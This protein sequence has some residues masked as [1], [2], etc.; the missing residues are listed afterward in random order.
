M[1]KKLNN[2][3]LIGPMGAGKTTIGK[4]LAQLTNNLFYD[5]DDEIEKQKEKDAKKEAEGS[6][7]VK[8]VRITQMQYKSY[9][10]TSHCRKQWLRK[11]KL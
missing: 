1:K 2:I 3:Y 8:R 9:Q 7:P 11:M 4:E 10:M 5:S 6:K